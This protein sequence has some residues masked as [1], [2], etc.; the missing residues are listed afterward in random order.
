MS[1]F[2]PAPKAPAW[3][4]PV[5]VPTVHMGPAV[6]QKDRLLLETTQMA[7]A[8][9]WGLGSVYDLNPNGA[10]YDFYPRP[11]NA[12]SRWFPEAPVSQIYNEGDD[13]RDLFEDILGPDEAQRLF[14]SAAVEPPKRPK[15][16][17]E[18]RVEEIKAVLGPKQRSAVSSVQN[19]LAP[20]PQPPVII[21]TSKQEAQERTGEMVVVG[22]GL[23]AAFGAGFFLGQ[24]NR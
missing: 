5:F 8:D 19:L 17:M 22:L 14:G 24:R 16:T 10:V 6:R 20:K 2:R 1:Y 13:D 12:E 9:R 18:Q 21:T 3:S 15:K 4:S 7:I 23:F 11:Q